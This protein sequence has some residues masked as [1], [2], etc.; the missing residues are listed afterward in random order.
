ML[1]FGIS[2]PT[3]PIQMPKTE[4]KNYY[5]QQLQDEIS[6]LKKE[7][8]YERLR[9]KAFETMIDIAENELNVNIRKKSGA[10]Q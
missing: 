10:K 1:N 7:L 5:E 9:S 6:R 4:K 2:E 8:E 3:K